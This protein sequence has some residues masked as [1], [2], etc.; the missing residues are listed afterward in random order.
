ME[1][2][3]TINL[4]HPAGGP[5]L[6]AGV[7]V[8]VDESDDYIKGQ[9]DAGYLVPV[10]KGSAHQTWDEN[11]ATIQTGAVTDLGGTERP[12]AGDTLERRAADEA[13]REAAKTAASKERTKD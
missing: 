13:R 10:K 7:P 5:P 6:P 11:A 9:V 4:A 3:S 12:A 1:A 8:I 2:V